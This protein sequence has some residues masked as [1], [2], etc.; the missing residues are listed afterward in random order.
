MR[1]SFAASVSAWAMICGIGAAPAFGQTQMPPDD[2][3]AASSPADEMEA[4]VVTGFRSSLAESLRL[5]REQSGVTDTIVAED[6]GKF[7]DANL[8]ESMQRVPGVA[9]QRG[10]G[11]EGRAITVRGLGPIFTRTRV[12]GMEAN[13]GVGGSDV[14]GTSGRSRGFDFN[15]FASEIFQNLTVR[16][17]YSADT[18]EG[19]LGATVDLNAPHPLDYKDDFVLVGSAKVSYNDLNEDAGPRL[20]GL[21][22]TKLADGTIGILFSAAY[23]QR[24]TREEGYSPANVLNAASDGGFCSPIG[25]APRNPVDNALKGTDA[26]NCA[27]GIPRTSD[28][29]A[30]ATV[31]GADAHMPRLPRYF[32]S[33]QNYKRLGLTGSLQ[34]QPTDRT[35]I[36]LDGLYARYKVNRVDDFFMGLSFGRGVGNNGKPHTSILDAEVSDDGT[37]Q[38]GLFNGVD[39]ASVTTQ[40]IYTT[41]FKQATLTAKHEFSDWFE[42]DALVG[43]GR[44]DF[45]EPTRNDVRMDANNVNGFS[46]DF[47]NRGSIPLI[48]YGIDITDPGN[49]AF[50]PALA[51][52]TV[53]GSFSG[54][55]VFTQFDNRQ[56]G[57]NLLF[58]PL[59]SLHIRVGG[60]YRRSAFDSAELG[61][62]GPISAFVPAL[63]VGTTLAGLTTMVGGFGKGLPGDLPNGWVKPDYDKFNDLFDFDSNTGGFTFSG[64][65]TGTSLGGNYAIREEVKGAYAQAE[66]DTEALPF[67]VRGNI[68]LRYVHTQQRS[69]GYVTLASPINGQGFTPVAVERSYDDWLPSLNLTADVTDKLLLRVSAAKVMARPDLGQL[70]PSG[71][72]NPTIRTISVGNALLDPIR[73][74]TLDLSAE[75]YFGSGSLLSVGY[76][77]KDIKT[78]IQSLQR[79]IPFTETGL[80]V[81]L[82]AG[83]QATPQDLFT[84]TNLSNTKGGPIKGVEVN[85]QQQFRFLPSVLANTGV[86]LNYT[87][88]TSEIE[89]ILNAT[90]GVTTREPLVGMSKNQVNA[91][92]YYEDDKFSIRGSANYRSKFV[93]AVP[94]I[95]T[96]SDIDLGK[97]TLYVDFSASYAINDRFRVSLE[98]TNLTDE[99]QVLYVDSVR[100]DTLYDSHF[101][102]TY[103][104]GVAY[105]Y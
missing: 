78:Y 60:E 100:R 5:K 69:F 94:S 24:R 29:E 22:S 6:I 45:K 36:S 43:F 102:R 11:G 32:R 74:N 30:Y 88:V 7:P 52:G 65:D 57:L 81:E 80:P 35:L 95:G 34:W 76:F 70:S 89:Y 26:L 73:A 33:D 79:I 98:A 64:A 68:G 97:S 92:L 37:V 4:I 72:F 56:F 49:F 101:G 104:L 54:R 2:A 105:R 103:T 9:L 75:W 67:R 21:V 17:T 99:H 50:G 58:K 38:Y 31:V 82:L 12:N 18:Q 27:T 62:A 48:D 59:E 3:A 87:H 51:D 47:R 10:D 42:A 25:Y 16:K 77:Y 63:P 19:S 91:T 90:T 71:G 86:L 96:G 53:R 66:F 40:D 46:F 93:R 85:F 84:V 61:R 1:N 39:V 14:Q 28:P 55:K 44:T 41:T 8:A 83:S 20:A 13:S 23:T 15:V